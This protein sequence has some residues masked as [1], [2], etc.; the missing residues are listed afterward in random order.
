MPTTFDRRTLLAG[1]LPLSVAAQGPHH[2][3]HH[4]GMQGHHAGEMPHMQDMQNIHGLFDEVKAIRR[5]VIKRDDGVEATTESD[6]PKV[7]SMLQAHVQQMKRRLDQG[8]PIR[9]W[10]PLYAA[11]FQN[12]KQVKLEI[13]Q[14]PKGVRIVQT[15][16]NPQA[17]KLIHA[18]AEAVTGFVNNGYKDMHR[19]HPVPE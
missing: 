8:H 7:A 14:T 9:M 13:A 19:E 4:H 17:V 2:G 18:H 15:G 3:E 12:Y 6:N 16:R 10:D 1:L 11:L 5:T